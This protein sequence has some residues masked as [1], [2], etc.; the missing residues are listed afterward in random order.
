MG[1]NFIFFRSLLLVNIVNLWPFVATGSIVTNRSSIY[2]WFSFALL[3]SFTAVL[4]KSFINT[5]LESKKI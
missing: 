5:R 4:K 3:I 1:K 2:F